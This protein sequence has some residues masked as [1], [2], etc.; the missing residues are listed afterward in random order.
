[1]K[2][3]FKNLNNDCKNYIIDFLDVKTKIILKYNIPKMKVLKEYKKFIELI[4][5]INYNKKLNILTKYPLF[6]KSHY[7]KFGDVYLENFC[8]NYYWNNPIIKIPK[9]TFDLK[10]VFNEYFHFE[11]L[12]KVNYNLNILDEF[13]SFYIKMN[14]NKLL[15]SLHYTNNKSQLILL[16]KINGIKKISRLNKKELIQKLL[17]I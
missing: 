15:D 1:M 11:N 8:Y 9:R 2:F 3:I 12:K 7:I 14:R 6:E 10:I 5:N 13:N 17:K 16:C 4:K